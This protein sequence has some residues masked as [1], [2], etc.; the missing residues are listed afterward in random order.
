[1]TPNGV[2]D[3]LTKEEL[4]RFEALLLERRALLMSDMRAMEEADA[5]DAVDPFLSSNHL[6]DLGSDR[7]A[8]DVSLGRRESESGEIQEID[9]ALGRIREGTF[10]LCEDCGARMP[11]GRLEAIP[12]ARYCLPCKMRE[13]A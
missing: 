4:D 2:T 7:A 1:M 5:R 10:G 9:D 13:E 8:S 3:G 6:A 12:Y 11:A